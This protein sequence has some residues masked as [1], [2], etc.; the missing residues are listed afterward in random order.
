M[1][2]L[3]N[4]IDFLALISVCGANPN[5]DP[6]HNGS[7]RVD[8]SGRGV[9]SPVCIKRKL[10]DRLAEMGEEIF[11]SPP[12]YAGDVLA[13][14]A[15]Q[16]IRGDDF[17]WKACTKWFDVRAF[18]QVFAF[19]G[20]NSAGI[21]GP[22]TIQ[23]AVSLHPVEIIQT[24]ITRCIANSE[25]NKG[26]GNIGFTSCVQYGLYV[27]KGSVNAYAA[28]KTGFG[29]GDSAKLHQALI[30]IFDNDSSAARPAGSME[31]KRLYW[32]EH[33]SAM[34]DYSPAQVFNTVSAELLTNSPSSFDDYRINHSPLPG[35]CPKIYEG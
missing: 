3:A 16:L 24:E 9:I 12:E 29:A 30:H 35:L 7:P 5:G 21:K 13:R 34:G 2:A 8:S 14:R 22:V 32:W 19:P 23:Q 27:L 17:A 11:V 4:R 20:Y 33:T 1:P 25:K 31:L 18:G 15:A 10:R 26:R 28:A 6:R